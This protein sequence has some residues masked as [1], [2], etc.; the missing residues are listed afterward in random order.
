MMLSLAVYADEL[1]TALDAYESGD[2]QTAYEQFTQLAL[3]DNAE[4][5]YNLAF[6]HYGGEGVPQD[7]VKAAYWF[8]QAARAGHA[9]AQDTLGYMYLNGR[10]HKVDRVRA[11]VWYSVAAEN[12]IF[13][14]KNVSANLR[15]Q[16]GAAERIHAD[17]LS[18]EYLKKYKK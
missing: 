14:A 11:Y 4:A 16:M 2:Y 9:A 10:G 15:K 8:E 18:R 13:L 12:G 5:Q 3:K 7:D 6:M 1:M 17:L